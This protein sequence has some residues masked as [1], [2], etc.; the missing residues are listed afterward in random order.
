MINGVHSAEES[1]QAVSGGG[2]FV[3]GL[4]WINFF[5]LEYVFIGISAGG[6]NYIGIN[7]STL[8]GPRTETAI[9]IKRNPPQERKT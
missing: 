4:Q 5:L 1:K 3:A 8:T 2:E 7:Q 9:W 6:C